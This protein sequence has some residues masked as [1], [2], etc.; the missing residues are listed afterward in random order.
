MG[1]PK[2]PFLTR[3]YEIAKEKAELKYQN[4]VCTEDEQKEYVRRYIQE[5]MLKVNQAR[6]ADELDRVTARRLLEEDQS[7]TTDSSDKKTG[8]VHV[9][10]PGRKSGISKKSKSRNKD[11]VDN[12]LMMDKKSKVIELTDA[13]IFPEVKDQNE[14][15]IVGTLQSH[16]NGFRYVTSSSQ[17]NVCFLYKDVK[18]AIYRVEEEKKMP[19]LLHFHLVRP[20]KVGTKKTEEIQLRLA[21]TP[22]VQRRSDDDSNEIEKEKQTSDYGHNEDL[23]IFVLRVQAKLRWVPISHYSFSEIV[24]KSKVESVFGLT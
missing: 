1:L 15:T 4:C 13:A 8:L 18:Q 14:E 9:L 12:K 24:K 5:E 22:V 7:K 2:C 3:G 21:P 11:C 6:L 10:K 17:F 20:V 23:K 19:P 16:V